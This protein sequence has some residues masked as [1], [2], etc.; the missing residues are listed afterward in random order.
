ML[1]RNH[2]RYKVISMTVDYLTVSIELSH[3]LTSIVCTV[4][5]DFRYQN[6]FHAGFNKL[7][8]SCLRENN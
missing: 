2:L 3:A 6:V 4:E 7:F 1:V 8:T 5:S